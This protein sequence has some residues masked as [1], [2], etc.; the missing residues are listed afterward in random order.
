MRP[1]ADDRISKNIGHLTH[2]APP[3]CAPIVPDAVSW[4]FFW[5]FT[6]NLKRIPLATGLLLTL[7]ACSAQE[8]PTVT[9]TRA[10]GIYSG[11]L[12]SDEAPPLPRRRGAQNFRW[13]RLFG[14]L[15]H[16]ADGLDGSALL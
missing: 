14:H 7:A 1:N 3:W 4:M 10:Q 5:R 2:H 11:T 13:R 9:G 6:M 8:A 15:G 16:A 12:D